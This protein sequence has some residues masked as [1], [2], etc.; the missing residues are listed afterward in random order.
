MDDTQ[1]KQQ[2]GAK[3]PRI[4]IWTGIP[5][6]IL[7]AILSCRLWFF[8]LAQ[9]QGGNAGF[10]SVEVVEFFGFLVYFFFFSF[11]IWTPVL[12]GTLIVCAVLRIGRPYYSW[13]VWILFAILLVPFFESMKLSASAFHQLFQSHP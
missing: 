3:V 12:G 10:V 1:S 8:I 4:V 7:A 11:S 2:N 9:G 13:K 6:C 5:S